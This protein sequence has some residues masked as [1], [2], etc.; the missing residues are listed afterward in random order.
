MTARQTDLLLTFGKVTTLIL[1]GLCALAAAIFILLIPFVLLV[2]QDMLGGFAPAEDF[3]L[4]QHA[5]LAYGGIA[6]LATALL[7]ALFVF[8]G[9]M[10]KIIASVGEG[11]PFIAENANRLNSMAWLLL[12][13]EILALL[14]G[15]LRLHLANLHSGGG[16]RL[17]F[18]VYDLTGFIVI[19]VLFILARV[20]RQGAAMRADLE[21]TV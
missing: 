7:G 3:P 10:R 12:A 5:P 2:S 8:F 13:V 4:M 6:V 1:Q 19:L 15:F 11:D 20:F 16:E 21:G 17:D 14:V 9:K 18:S